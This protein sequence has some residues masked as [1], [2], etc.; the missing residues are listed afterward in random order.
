MNDLVTLKGNAIAAL[1]IVRETN[2]ADIYSGFNGEF[3]AINQQANDLVTTTQT[4]IA[5]HLGWLGDDGEPRPDAPDM[6]ATLYDGAADE[7]E[8]MAL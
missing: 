1:R 6:V 5:C 3:A 2:D 7:A 4:A 8:I